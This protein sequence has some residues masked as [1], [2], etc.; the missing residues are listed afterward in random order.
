MEIIHWPCNRLT[1]T[2]K[3]TLNNQ[4]K[5]IFENMKLNTSCTKYTKMYFKLKS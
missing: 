1:Y 2:V 3:K 5:N 4:R